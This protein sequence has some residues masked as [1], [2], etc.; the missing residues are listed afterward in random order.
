MTT[1]QDMFT[2]AHDCAQAIGEILR[3]GPSE[4]GVTL[5]ALIERETQVV[6]GVRSL[7]TP[8]PIVEE[9]NGINYAQISRLSEELRDIAGELAPPW[10]RTDNGWSRPTSELVTVVCRSGDASITPTEEQFHWG[11]R[12]SN[13][14]AAAFAGEIFVV[15]PLGWAALYG[16]WQGTLP[17]LG[18]E[19]DAVEVTP[20]IEDAE[21][22]LA[23]LSSGLLGPYSR[24]CLLCYV[25]RML[26]EHDC[27]G[28]LRFAAHYRDVRAPRAT[29]LERRLGRVGSHCDCE[30]FLNASTL[31]PVLWVVNE[32]ADPPALAWPEPL[33]GC[34]GVRAGSV[35]PCALWLSA[36]W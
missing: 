36:R 31:R 7:L 19:G 26:Q 4:A 28:R 1:Y 32:E 13:H 29:A 9:D 18:A 30:L 5:V 12:Y 25:Y 35:Q 16:Q 27:N 34:P 15:T 2:G 24:E 33:P 14:G 11:W 23:E 6:L 17:A 10:I 22:L 8:I 3:A 21:K 20:E